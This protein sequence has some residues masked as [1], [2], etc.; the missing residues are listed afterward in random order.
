MTIAQSA[1]PGATGSDDH[2]DHAEPEAESDGPSRLERLR[3]VGFQFL[4]VFL[5]AILYFLV[6]GLTQ[7]H[8][9]TAVS[10]AHEVLR[11]ERALGIDVEV[12]AQHLVLDHRPLVTAFNWVYMWG[13]WPVIATALLVLY[14][15]DRRRYVILRNAMF[16][17]GA[18]GLVIFATWPVA[19]PRLIPGGADYVD[20]VTKWSTSYRVLQPPGLVNKFA[21]M[22][23]YHVGWNLLVG[24]ALWLTFRRPVVRALAVASPVLMSIAVVVTANHFVLDGIVG[25]ALALLGLAA[26]HAI[27]S[28]AARHGWDLSEVHLWRRRM[29]TRKKRG[30]EIQAVHDDGV[31]AP[32]GELFRL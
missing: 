6:R 17:S 19:P 15:K 7:G 4:L 13:H 3:G 27:Y 8:E 9:S 1:E 32:L 28:G 29:R 25:A 22:P 16:L 20:T 26:S 14:S 31:D 18:V 24:I 5:A 12:G 11:F 23:S 2:A 21:A 30:R 10:H